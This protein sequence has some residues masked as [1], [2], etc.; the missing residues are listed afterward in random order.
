MF[1]FFRDFHRVQRIALGLFYQP[2]A[3]AIGLETLSVKELSA[4]NMLI[5]PVGKLYVRDIRVIDT[6]D[7][8]LTLQREGFII[9]VEDKDGLPVIQVVA[10]GEV[11]ALAG[12]NFLILDPIAPEKEDK[13]LIF[14]LSKAL[15]RL[16][17]STAAM[18]C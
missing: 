15:S 3:Y 17:P 6:L 8:Q 13:Q 7:V 14:A 11:V 16:N 9:P 5:V 10:D 1:N 12:Q 4:G 18:L 2:P